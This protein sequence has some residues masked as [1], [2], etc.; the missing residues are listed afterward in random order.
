[1]ETGMGLQ[2]STLV[3]EQ[4]F[5]GELQ[6]RYEPAWMHHPAYQDLTTLL[7]GQS[8]LQEL[9]AFVDA[10]DHCASES[11]SL[12]Q[13][14]YRDAITEVPADFLEKGGWGFISAVYADAMSWFVGK[15]LRDPSERDYTIGSLGEPGE[16]AEERW[17]YAE[18]AT[19]FAGQLILAHD[20]KE[21]LR[22]QALHL[23]LRRTWRN[24]SQARQIAAMITQLEMQRGR[25][26]NVFSQFGRLKR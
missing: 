25:L 13:G 6:V 8:I 26:L 19:S 17:L 1:M 11:A 10:V 18:E 7:K 16:G 2:V 15:S 12:L 21:A 22:L 24:S 14:I 20:D 5:K 9:N 4:L 23:R 3:Y